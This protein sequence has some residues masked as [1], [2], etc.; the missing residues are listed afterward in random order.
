MDNTL[1]SYL[2]EAIFSNVTKETFLEE[3]ETDDQEGYDKNSDAGSKRLSSVNSF[4]SIAYIDDDVDIEIAPKTRDSCSIGE[5]DVYSVVDDD[6][7]FKESDPSFPTDSTSDSEGSF[8]TAPNTLSREDGVNI[9]K[10]IS[11]GSLLRNEKY[12]SKK[13]QLFASVGDI[14]TNI[15]PAFTRKLS[16]RRLRGRKE[17][18]SDPAPNI[19]VRLTK[20]KG[21]H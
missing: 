20:Y 5:N 1:R 17:K 9:N 11:N 18:Y 13:S 8:R 10:A 14:M 7:V 19:Y 16:L 3:D 2:T 21:Y 6:E 12:R 15:S 4:Q